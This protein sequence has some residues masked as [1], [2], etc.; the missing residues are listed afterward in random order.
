MARKPQYRCIIG[1]KVE[2]GWKGEPYTVRTSTLAGVV[3]AL[4]ATGPAV[5]VLVTAEVATMK[6]WPYN[7]RE[8]R[9]CYI[10]KMQAHVALSRLPKHSQSLFVGVLTGMGFEVCHASTGQ[11]LPLEEVA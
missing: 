10:T 8:A 4:L 2:W 11:Q 9:L 5:W 1:Y 6:T 3:S 7:A